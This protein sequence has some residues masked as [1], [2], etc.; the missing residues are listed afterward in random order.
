MKNIAYSPVGKK[1]IYQNK[2]DI[3]IWVKP[4]KKLR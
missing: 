2:W 3:N 4:I 1:K